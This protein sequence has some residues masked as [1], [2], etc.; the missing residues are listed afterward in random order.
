MREFVPMIA[1]TSPDEVLAYSR[2]WLSHSRTG[3]PLRRQE[4]SLLES[5]FLLDLDVKKVEARVVR[6]S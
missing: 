1:R 6:A 2:E 3:A 4:R 5:A